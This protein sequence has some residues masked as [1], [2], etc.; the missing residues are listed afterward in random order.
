MTCAPHG[1]SESQGLHHHAAPRVQNADGVVLGIYD[2][3]ASRLAALPSGFQSFP[4]L[5][6]QLRLGQ[7]LAVGVAF[8]L[9][10]L[11]LVIKLIGE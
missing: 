7:A 9:F 10:L 5:L 8:Q 2:K 4:K 6:L 1:P 11:I 3:E